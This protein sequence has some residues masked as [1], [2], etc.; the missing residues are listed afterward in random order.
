MVRNVLWNE[1][2]RNIAGGLGIQQDSL[3]EAPQLCRSLCDT[4]VKLEEDVQTMNDL[5][6]EGI[7]NDNVCTAF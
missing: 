1:Y 3:I 5:A 2:L 6:T 7:N 4:I